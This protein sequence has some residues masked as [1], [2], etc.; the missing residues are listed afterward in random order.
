[1]SLLGTGP[2]PRMPFKNSSASAP[3]GHRSVPLSP[4][5]PDRQS[6]LRSQLSHATD[7][8]TTSLP[9]SPTILLLKP[10]ANPLPSGARLFLTGRKSLRPSSSASRV[11]RNAARAAATKAILP[12]KRFIADVPVP[13]GGGLLKRKANSSQA[14]CHLAKRL[15]HAANRPV[16]VRILFSSLRYELIGSTMT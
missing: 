2:L 1:M 14:S 8:A 11:T 12:M 15:Q 5:M 3:H 13:L 4:A 7:D 6:C 10:K 16:N 9:G